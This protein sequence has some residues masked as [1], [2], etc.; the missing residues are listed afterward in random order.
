MCLIICGGYLFSEPVVIVHVDEPV[1]AVKNRFSFFED[2]SGSATFSFVRSSEKTLFSELSETKDGSFGFQKNPYWFRVTF[3]Y[4][5]NS[6][7]RFSLVLDYSLVDNVQLYAI[8]EQG[9]WQGASNLSQRGLPVPVFP[10]VLQPGNNT[11]YLRIQTEGTLRVP[12]QLYQENAFAPVFFHNI[13]LMGVYFGAVLL[14]ALIN[15][16]FFSIYKDYSRWASLFLFLFIGSYILFQS[17]QSGFAQIFISRTEDSLFGP[18]VISGTIG[19]VALS[20]FIFFFF[21]QQGKPLQMHWLFFCFWAASSLVLILVFWTRA[22]VYVRWFAIL[23]ALSFIPNLSLILRRKK[24]DRLFERRWLLVTYMVLILGIVMFGLRGLG[25][26]PSNRITL[27]IVPMSM[28][29]FILMLTVLQFKRVIATIEERSALELR[30]RDLYKASQKFIP[31]GFLSF[32]QKE[33]IEDIELGD[34]SDADLTLLFSDIRNFTSIV[35]RLS[36]EESFELLNSYFKAIGP[37]VRSHNGF[38]DKYIGDGIMAVFPLTADDALAAAMEMEEALEELNEKFTARGWPEIKT[39]IGIHCG[40]CIVG[41]IGEESRMDTTVISDVVNTAS[42][43][44]GLT[45]IFDNPILISE[46]VMKSLSNPMAVPLRFLGK[47]KVKGKTK[48]VS[49]FQVLYDHNTTDLQA[50]R[51]MYSYFEQGM[52]AF[53]Q[54]DFKKAIVLFKKV[55]DSNPQ[56]RPTMIYLRQA[57]QL[58]KN[59]IPP[60][61]DG[62]LK[63]EY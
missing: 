35:E 49:V 41:T 45:K 36:P 8:D 29:L 59:G 28:F 39:G 47:I 3:Y 38:I 24:G 17:I 42:R 22:S 6:K 57:I 50:N 23:G 27:N 62:Y 25:F 21:K 16:I 5:G 19:L 55:L 52:F 43:L 60:Q 12:L 58:Y 13:S 48:A 18:Y 2:T 1:I 33:S 14:L 10:V 31:Q 37:I 54:K 61:W 20:L 34:L 9:N 7:K 32:L 11:L 26:V 15:L 53:F 56:D 46:E 40:P 4:T 63:L 44:E 51:T 30:W